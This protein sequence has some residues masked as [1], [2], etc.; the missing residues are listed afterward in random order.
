MV[1]DPYMCGRVGGGVTFSESSVRPTI[2]NQMNLNKKRD[3]VSNNN[4]IETLYRKKKHANVG[5]VSLKERGR[6]RPS[7]T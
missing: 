2:E 7:N 4:K 3:L 5:W 1:T 6:E